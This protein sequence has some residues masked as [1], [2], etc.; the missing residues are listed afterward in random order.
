MSAATLSDSNEFAHI[1]LPTGPG[2]YT[3]HRGLLVALL[4]D[5]S[6]VREESLVLSIASTLRLVRCG[7]T[8]KCPSQ[9]EEGYTRPNLEAIMADIARQA[10]GTGARPTHRQFE[11]EAGA[12]VSTKVRFYFASTQ[13]SPEPVL[14][15]KLNRSTAP[16]IASEA[17]S[18]T[19]SMYVGMAQGI[20]LAADLAVHIQWTW[21]VP[22]SEV[23]VPFILTSWN[24]VQFGAVYLIDCRVPCA[25]LLSDVLTLTTR[26]HQLLIARWVVALAAHCH[27]M[28]SILDEQ[29][30][31]GYGSGSRSSS[32]TRSGPRVKL[33]HLYFCKLLDLAGDDASLVHSALARVLAVYE[34]LSKHDTAT[35]V[36]SFP[37][38]VVGFPDAIKQP[39]L[40]ALLTTKISFCQSQSGRGA[41]DFTPCPGHP[42]LI[43]DDLVAEGWTRADLWMGTTAPSGFAARLLTALT[44]AMAAIE[45]AGI[46]HLDLRLPNVFYRELPMPSTSSASASDSSGAVHSLQVRIIDWSDAAFLGEPI[47]PALLRLRK[48]DDRFPIDECEW[49]R[50]ACPEYHTFFLNRMRVVLES[51]GHRGSY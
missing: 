51:G 22:T 12:A 11:V 36:V 37:I 48:D 35:S 3:P 27:R 29:V 16:L 21:N 7:L 19:D 4:G 34:A 24:A 8:Y 50:I 25:V 43:F 40:A 2:S 38:G 42:V 33:S 17:K 44:Q 39:S 46:I 15:Y 49:H 26:P 45:A 31:S 30:K 41:L 1:C 5:V 47:P 9:P 23:V 6:A 13:S 18:L 32:R 28:A 14:A 10:N 20:Q